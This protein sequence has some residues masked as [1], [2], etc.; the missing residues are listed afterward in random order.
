MA[1]ISTLVSRVFDLLTCRVMRIVVSGILSLICL[2]LCVLGVY[3]Y[4]GGVFPMSELGGPDDDTVD[5]LICFIVALPFGISAVA[6][7][8]RKWWAW[9]P[10]T[11]PLGLWCLPLVSSFV[12]L[13]S[14]FS[15]EW[16]LY[17]CSLIFPVIF[18]SLVVFL[19]ARA[20]PNAPMP[21]RDSTLPL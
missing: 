3:L 14:P 12:K 1:T 9:I 10:L 16:V 7:A 6:T 11:L 4:R 17:A 13:E 20:K 2:L 18:F 5:L 8:L 19:G 21:P 15:S